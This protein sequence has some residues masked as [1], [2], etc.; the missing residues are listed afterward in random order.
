MKL[1]KIHKSVVSGLPSLQDL[2]SAAQLF[3]MGKRSAIYPSEGGHIT[4][5]PVPGKK[6]NL[7]AEQYSRLVQDAL[8]ENDIDILIDGLREM[9][10]ELSGR[11][12]GQRLGRTS[13]PKFEAEVEKTEHQI[14]KP[15]N[16]EIGGVSG[17]SE[18]GLGATKLYK[19]GTPDH[20]EVEVESDPEYEPEDALDDT[21]TSFVYHTHPKMANNNYFP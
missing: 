7:N 1:D 4:I 18:G 6:P 9:G 10:F 16:Q 8:A 5:S 12:D 21:D 13:D 3:Q 20:V 19:V 15:G 11:V 17:T 2:L 14:P